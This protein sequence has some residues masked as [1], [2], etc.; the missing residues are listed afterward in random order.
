MQKTVHLESVALTLEAASP[1][2][3]TFNLN[4]LWAIFLPEDK[5]L[6]ISLPPRVPL[7]LKLIPEKN[8]LNQNQQTI[9]NLRRDLSATFK[10]PGQAENHGREASSASETPLRLS[11]W[12][13]ALKEASGVQGVNLY[14]GKLYIVPSGLSWTLKSSGDCPLF[15]SYLCSTYSTVEDQ[16]HEGQRD[17][18]LN[19]L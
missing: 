3:I 12:M 7:I 5:I 17:N 8:W 1:Q 18:A 10:S 16:E 13:S 9:S 4:K 11:S 19:S 6:P 14:P 15:Y 2:P